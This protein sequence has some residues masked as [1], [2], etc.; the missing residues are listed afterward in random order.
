MSNRLSLQFVECRV[1]QKVLL[2]VL[3]QVIRAPSDVWWQLGLSYLKKI[4]PLAW[5]LDADGRW[6]PWFKASPRTLIVPLKEGLIGVV[7][8][9]KTFVQN[10]FMSIF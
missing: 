1:Q 7:R 10:R 5:V 9:Q 2:L 3:L 6:I 8:S 4:N